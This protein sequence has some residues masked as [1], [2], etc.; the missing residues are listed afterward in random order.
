MPD[1]KREVCV[2]DWEFASAVLTVLLLLSMSFLQAQKYTKAAGN[3]AARKQQK[4][5]PKTSR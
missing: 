2:S 3:S 5:K 4:Q 1:E